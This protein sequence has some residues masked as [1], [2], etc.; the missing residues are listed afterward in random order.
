MLSIDLAN[1]AFVFVVFH[2]IYAHNVILCINLHTWDIKGQL[3]AYIL[4]ISI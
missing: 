2:D 1:T 3:M 4:Y